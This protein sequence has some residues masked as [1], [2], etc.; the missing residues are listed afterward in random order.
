MASEFL[1]IVKDEETKPK[2]QKNK[3]VLTVDRSTFINDLLKFHESR[4]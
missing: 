4:G 2:R 3:N 1:S